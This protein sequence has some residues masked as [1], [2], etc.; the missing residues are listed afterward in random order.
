MSEIIDAARK[1]FQSELDKGLGCYEVKEWGQKIYWKPET[2]DQKRRILEKYRES[3]ALGV[4]ECVIVR[5]LDSEG[6]RL[7]KSFDRNDL[8]NNVDG[9]VLVNIADAMNTKPDTV[10]DAKKN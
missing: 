6:K 9:D 1:H 7:F 8:L 10:E 5:A 4:I 3:E 2:M